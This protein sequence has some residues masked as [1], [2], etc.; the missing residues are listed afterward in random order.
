MAQ[1]FFKRL[2]PKTDVFSR[3]LYANPF[4]AVPQKVISAL[5]KHDIPFHGHTST[6]LT[7]NDLQAANLIFCMEQAHEELLLDRY[8]QYTDKIWLLTDFAYDKRKDIE[9]PIS[10]EGH[11]FEK[12]ADK[13][14][15]TCQAAAKRIE[16]DFSTQK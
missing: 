1:E 4:Y 3:G 13:L 14:Y 16:Q 7:A 12:V 11:T 15:Q 9:D 2:L 8:A 5:A 6:R 10:L